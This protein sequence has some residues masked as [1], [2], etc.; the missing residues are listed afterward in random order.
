MIHMHMSAAEMF[1]HGLH[2]LIL[3]YFSSHVLRY[4]FFIYIYQV[5]K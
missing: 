4:A 2:M 5:E 3:L 1:P